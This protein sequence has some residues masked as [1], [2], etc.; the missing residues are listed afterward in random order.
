MNEGGRQGAPST[1]G[2][3]TAGRRR[4]RAEAGGLALLA[5]ALAFNVVF[6]KG[7][8][9]VSA[10]PL[11]DEVFHSVASQRLA[12]AIA[13]GEPFLDPWVPNWGFGFPVWRSYQPLP[14]LVA[15]AAV[16]SA[17]P[18]GETSAFALLATIVTGLLP[19]ALYAGARIFGLSATASG[20]ASLLCLLP[21]GAGDFG[22]YGLSYGASVWLG[23]GLYTQQFAL[24]LLPL[25]LGLARQ[26]LD[27]G[28][29]RF[30]AG[31][32]LALAAL[33]HIV[34]GYVGA[35]AV[36]VL[37]LV[38]SPGG[39]ASR[40]VRVAWIAA[41]SFLLTA[42]FTIPLF[43]S[44]AE[45]NHSRFEPGV[46]W[47]SYGSRAILTA[48]FNGSLL[49]FGRLPVLT[50]L[51]GLAVAGG[52]LLRRDGA[53]RR[54]L[55]LT[56][57]LFA[58]FLGR[59]TW[60]HLLLLLGVP[61]DL[62]LHR[63][64]A[65]FE[66]SACLLAA[67]FADAS[68]REL[69][70]RAPPL[71]VVAALLLGAGALVA[72]SERAD[73]LR[74][75]TRL[76]EASLAAYRAEEADFR[77]AVADV[78]KLI[79][80]RPGR[81]SAG[82]AAGWGKDFKIGEVPVYSLL[83][84]E[85]LDQASFLFHSLSRAGDFVLTR[86][87]WNA[88]HDDVFGIRAVVAPADRPA[89]PHL[90]PVGRH[91]RFAVYEASRNGYFGL[92]DVF[93]SYAGP[94]STFYEPSAAW[95]AT[96]LPRAGLFVAL[97]P[98][99][100]GLPSI[101]RWQ[102][103]PPAPP[104]LE[105][106][107]GEIVSVS[108]RPGRWKAGVRLTRP[109]QVILKAT[110]FPDLA[111]TVDGVAVPSIRVTPEF[112][113][114][115]V[116]AGDHIVEVV[117]RPSPAKPVLFVAGIAAFALMAVVARRQR[118]E[119]L[120]GRAERAVSRALEAISR[121]L[122]FSAVPL[123]VLLLLSCHALLRGLLVSGHDATAYPPRLVE[124][125]KAVLDGHI[126]PVWAAD[127][128]AGH[129]QPLFEFNPPLSLIAPFL[130]RTAGFRL[131]DSL[132]LGLFLLVGLGAL[133]LY[134]L[135]R[136][137]PV[138]RQAAVGAAAFWLFSPYLHTDLL[139]RG[140]WAEAA[141]LAVSPVALLALSRLL[142]RAPSVTAFV[143][144]AFAMAAVILGHNAVALLFMPAVCLVILAISA[145]RPFRVTPALAAGG[146]VVCALALSVFFWAPAF[147][148]SPWVKTSLLRTDP[149]QHW[150]LHFPTLLQL[151]YSPWGFGQSV[152]GPNDGMSFM[153]GPLQ[154][155]AG[156]V[157][158]WAAFRKGPGPVR[159][160]A[161]GAAAASALGL[162]LTSPVSAFIW[163]RVPPLQYLVFPWRALGLPTIFLPILAAIA[164][165]GL[166]TRQV[167]AAI[168]LVVVLNLSH[169]EP[170]RYLTFDEEYYEPHNIAAAGL[171]SATFDAFEPRWVEQRPPYT[172]VPLSAPAGI[173]LIERHERTAR[174]DYVVRLAQGARV[175]AAT[176][177]Y[178][179]WRV[180]IDGQAVQ[181]EIVPVRGT[182][183]FSVPEGVHRISLVFG[184][185]LLRTVTL[186]VSVLSAAILI[187]ASVFSL[188]RAAR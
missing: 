145:G 108:A 154:L 106:P 134:R 120:D 81:V 49:D 36:V 138:S 143:A 22:R 88:A 80:A 170:E 83:T 122:P 144:T 148:E 152:P 135:A 127:F 27:S 18:G 115:T 58:L 113:A 98:G 44:R 90:R 100:G 164:L 114:A 16:S 157:G 136:D 128:G 37:A 77:A 68:I 99:G 82:Q 161:V 25:A 53:G 132:Q 38:G 10:V 131:A 110:F 50:A 70:R 54:L 71:H 59:D 4:L 103:F 188:S 179:E 92:G 181:T 55:A 9:R 156:G 96:P 60:G 168:G 20:L 184:R 23:S 85:R 146:A 107:R 126:P 8:A 116:P 150:W 3:V 24:L 91:G 109:C 123:T 45:I 187:V 159:R 6:L 66:L 33:S 129:G 62:H 172:P 178:P 12:D 155:L 121:K 112:S 142:G 169:T 185:T 175:E 166:S 46:K 14:H 40:I 139:V 15:A 79:E 117:Y 41:G 149:T 101:A 7:E 61:A 73:Y 174:R 118:L 52:F 163:E 111:F 35:L 84:L 89:P 69:R 75:N 151:L 186:L 11:N 57:V 162:V 86:S 48:L 167:F 160:L 125:A 76:G 78:R 94:P 104:E 30:A 31:A 1:R 102:P 2:D 180:E 51:V 17:S 137:I 28:R 42:W 56:L 141:A 171:V 165:D 97:G 124:F 43:L 140:A 26:A 67:W 176:F 72:F 153:V 74:R 93:A 64:Q 119:V 32:A 130:L 47:D 147:V 34:F 173:E 19:L 65:A 63:L 95:L 105:T 13:G 87:E 21:S 177:W 29:W 39:R 182:I 158:L 133:A 183:S 5:I